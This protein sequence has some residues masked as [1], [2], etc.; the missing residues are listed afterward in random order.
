[1]LN[2][3]KLSLLS[4]VIP[5]DLNVETTD[6]EIPLIIISFGIFNLLFVMN[7]KKVFDQLRS[8]LLYKH[9]FI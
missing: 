9:Q 7:I 2:L 5:S 3:V 1:M 4:K 6:T 8:S